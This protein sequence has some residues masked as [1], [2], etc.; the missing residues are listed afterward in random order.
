[1]KNVKKII[2]LAMC[3][4]MLVGVSVTG[5]LA[6]LTATETVNNT[7]TVGK[8]NL[9]GDDGSAGLDEA[10]VDEYGVEVQGADRVQANEY[11]LIPGHTY[12]KDPTIHV[13]SDSE[14]C[15]LFAKIE[16]GIE[17]IEATG[18]TTIAAQLAKNNW[19]VYDDEC[20]DYTIYVYKDKVCTVDSTAQDVLVFSSFTLCEDAV[21]ADYADACVVV[22]AYAV[23]ADGLT[24]D[25]AWDALAEKY[26]A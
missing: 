7:F 3:A 24:Q 21:V 20:E 12:T 18:D 25:E 14:E 4:V 17:A 13:G 15:Y 9:G 23:Q 2:A 6:F 11:K 22:T 10:K 16:N 5:T 26:P 19:E 1:M 8:V